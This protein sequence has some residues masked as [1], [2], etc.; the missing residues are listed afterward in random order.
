MYGNVLKHIGYVSFFGLSLVSNIVVA[1]LPDLAPPKVQLV[2]DFG[3]NVHSG[4]VQSSLDTVAIGGAMGLSHS[5]SNFTNNFSISGYRGYQDKFYAKGRVTDLDLR[6]ST[7]KNVMRVHDISGSADFELIVGGVP[8]NFGTGAVSNY[9]YRALG[10][11]R[12]LLEQRSD[13][14]YWT[15]PDGT[16]VQFTSGAIGYPDQIGLMKQIKYPNGFTIDVDYANKRVTTNTGFALKYIHQYDPADATLEPAK[17]VIRYDNTVPSVDP[18]TWAARNPK[19]IQAINNSVENCLTS[20]CVKSWPKA[21]FKWP[22]GMPRAIFLGDSTFKVTNAIGAVTEYYFRSFD[23]AYSGANLVEGYQPYKN[24]SPRLIGIKPAGA[25]DKVYQ[26][27][28][29]NVF[30]TQNSSEFTTWVLLSSDAGQVQT[31]KRYNDSAGYSIGDSFQIGDIQNTSSGYIQQVLPKLD[32]FPG[33]I[34]KVTTKE[35]SWS[36]EVSYRNFV[37]S[38]DPYFGPTE[39]YYYDARGNLSKVTKNGTWT[40][41]D[42]PTSCTEATL[43]YCNQP[44]WTSDAKNNKTYYTYHPESGQVATVTYPANKNGL[45]AQTRYEYESKQAYYYTVAGSKAYGSPIWL[46]TAEKYC[47]NS[48]YVGSSCTG[49]DEV[50]VRFE[51]NNDNLFMT[52]KTVFSQKDNKTL[53]TCYEYDSYGNKIG[54]TQPNANLTSCN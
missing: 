34:N 13:G 5:I 4:Q 20:N 10:D 3:V 37:E 17:A 46:K 39:S 21:E 31:A 14:V 35:G 11:T 6:P 42:Y 33:A 32:Q 49:N 41:A 19:Y 27:T 45:I 7:Y 40:S 50:V 43:K 25:T 54:E 38:Y 8:V 1:A 51:Y 47:T 2:D 16:V 18:Q 26:Y 23:L 22:A 53:R 52:G 44:N 12:N 29:K 24:Y 28:Y 30:Q 15:K 9:S 36:Y 48:N